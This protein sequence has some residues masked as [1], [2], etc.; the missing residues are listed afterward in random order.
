ML[1]G[2]ALLLATVFLIYLMFTKRRSFPAGYIA[3]S[4]I[5]AVWGGLITASVAALGLAESYLDPGVVRDFLSAALWTAYMLSSERVRATFVRTR[6][7]PEPI[8]QP[9]ASVPQPVT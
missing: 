1:A 8:T 7:A 6:S 9:E 3:L 5:G 4:W 2:H